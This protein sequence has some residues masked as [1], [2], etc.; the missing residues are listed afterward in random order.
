MIDNKGKVA[1]VF[2]VRNESSIAWDVALKLHQS[3]CKVALSYMADTQ[4]EVLYLM[5]QAGMDSSH[6]AGV[7]VRNELEITAFI[8]KVYDGLGP[9][10][11]ILHG[12]AWGS[13]SVMCYTLP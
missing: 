1:V 4:K 12:V 2:G 9:I 8:Q 7:D 6:T 11:Y 13:Q 3:G 5:E 10:N